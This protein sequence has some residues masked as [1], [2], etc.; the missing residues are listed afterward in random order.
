MS[1]VN[2]PIFEARY[3]KWHSLTLTKTKYKI[4]KW[5][6]D[7]FNRVWCCFGNIAANIDGGWIF[8]DCA[9]EETE[10]ETFSATVHVI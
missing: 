10:K 6:I 1:K 4:L 9:G 8:K 7:G 3:K 5:L 2:L